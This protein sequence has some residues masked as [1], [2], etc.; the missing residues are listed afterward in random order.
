LTSASAIREAFGSD[1]PTRADFDGVDV[2]YA[3]R[4]SGHCTVLYMDGIP[5]EIA[6]WGLSGD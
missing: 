3:P 1:R 6:F 2:E 4:W 5:D